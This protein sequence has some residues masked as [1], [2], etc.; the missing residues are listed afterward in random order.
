MEYLEI[1]AQNGHIINFTYN[2]GRGAFTL[3]LNNAVEMFSI[4]D[5]KRFFTIADSSAEGS[6]SIAEKVQ[7][8]TA[9][10]L[11]YEKSFLNGTF[12]KNQKMIE[13]LEKILV[14]LSDSFGISCDIQK[15][16][17]IAKK[18]GNGLLFFSLYSG[19]TVEIESGTFCKIS[20]IWFFISKK[21]EIKKGGYTIT[22]P[23]YGSTVG[24]M[25]STEKAAIDWIISSGISDILKNP[26]A[27]RR[28]KLQNIRE[29]FLKAVEN[30]GL[31]WVI[32][33]NPAYFE[34]FLTTAEAPAEAAEMPQNATEAEAPQEITA[35]AEKT[36]EKAI[37]APTECAHT[38]E[39]TEATAE[40]TAPRFVYGMRLRGYSIGCQ[41]DGVTERRDDP[42]GRY[43]DII[44]YNR[45]LSAEEM[46][47][48]ALDDLT[49]AE[50]ARPADD[51]AEVTTAATPAEDLTT[52]DTIT[53]GTPCGNPAD[54]VT[55]SPAE[56]IT[57]PTGCAKPADS[58]TARRAARHTL[59][60]RKMPHTTPKMPRGYI[61]TIDG[62]KARHGAKYA[63]HGA[64]PGKPVNNRFVKSGIPRAR[65]GTFETSRK[66]CGFFEKIRVGFHIG[67]SPP[68][69]YQKISL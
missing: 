36:A 68:G 57:A 12:S 22:V 14:F 47:H 41:P 16:E 17:K 2:C 33:S 15:P 35:E 1:I 24:T 64:S 54:I 18:K 38:A 23:A 3:D 25:H 49:P 27:G 29:N 63:P 5:F 28:E 39:T 40:A 30:S 66:I 61:S 56:T 37:N 19:D 55:G 31:S 9:A 20:D 69:G 59:T 44:V 60:T 10:R 7:E 51:P 21:K 6:F 46:R 34:D 53:G 32:E 58:T 8:F 43:Y 11:E 42:N 48:F 4:S 13:K 52:A 67:L 62:T 26:E 65:N 50:V 45:P